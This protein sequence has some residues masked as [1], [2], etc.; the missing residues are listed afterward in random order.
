MK[1]KKCNIIAAICIFIFIAVAL[2][3]LLLVVVEPQNGRS[4]TVHIIDT[5]VLQADPPAK[6]LIKYMNEKYNKNFVQVS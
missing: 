5:I 3:V 6:K 2:A 4:F 1:L